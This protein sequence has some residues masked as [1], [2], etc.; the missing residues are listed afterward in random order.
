MTHVRIANNFNQSRLTRALADLAPDVPAAP[1]QTMP[2][3]LGRWLGVAQAI[4][5]HA[6]LAAPQ[7]APASLM[8]DDHGALAAELAR[9]G[10]ALTDAIGGT[11]QTSARAG[12]SRLPMPPA[13]GSLAPDYAPYRRYYSVL[14]QNMGAAIAP[15]RKRVRQALR[16]ASPRLRQLAELDSAL[17]TAFGARE[18][19]LLAS[20]PGQLEACFRGL[21]QAH[22]AALI[23]RPRADDSARWL[24]EFYQRMQAVLLA[25]VEMRLLPL[26][27]MI[28]EY[29]KEVTG[30]Q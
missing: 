28:D 12:R 9:V 11:E 23:E 20:I 21:Y 8:A 22:Q 13:D 3:R 14:Q 19:D 7:A 5:L 24:N 2:E 27:A 1:S 17:E 29:A 15:L 10:K 25:E 6:A 18:A 26:Q 16:Q 4:T 30:N